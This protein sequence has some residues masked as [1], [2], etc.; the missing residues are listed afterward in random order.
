MPFL[1]TVNLAPFIWIIAA[2]VLGIIEAVTIQLVAI[3]F[4]LGALVAVIPAAMGL[5]S[6]AQFAVFIVV[7]AVSLICTRPFLKKVMQPQNQKTNADQV[8]G[9]TAVV[10]QRIDNDHAQGRVQVLGLDWAARSIDGSIIPEGCKVRVE[11]IEGVKLLVTFM[12]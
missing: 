2:V 1:D 12:E 6:T 9:K 4:A 8:L 10:L 11:A 7:S 5:P 3:W